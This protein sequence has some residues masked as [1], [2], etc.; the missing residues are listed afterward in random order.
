MKRTSPLPKSLSAFALHGCPL[1]LSPRHQ[2]IVFSNFLQGFVL[3]IGFKD[4]YDA[5]DM[6][7]FFLL[8]INILSFAILRD[9]CKH[10]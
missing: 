10:R 7:H 6:Q 8:E 5:Y 9:T 1:L 4:G 3:A 2:E